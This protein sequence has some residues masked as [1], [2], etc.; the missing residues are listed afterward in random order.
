MCEWCGVSTA[1]YY[2]WRN[3]SPSRRRLQRAC[4]EAA[5]IETFY[6]FKQRYGAPRLT[7][8]LNESG[9][10][11]S[12]THVAT[13]MAENKL[14][15]RNGKR[16]RYTPSN[17]LFSHVSENRLKR[18]FE[19]QRPNEKWVSDITYIR[20]EKGFVYLAVIMDLFSRRIVGWAMDRKMTTDLVIEAFEMAVGNRKV[21]PGLVLHSDRGVQ[22]RS[23][24]YQGRLLDCG[25]QP[26]MSRKGNCWDNAVIESFFSRLKVES[27]HAEKF[28]GLGDAYTEV[29]EYIEL[30]YNTI[31]RH[32]SNGYL[33]PK[34][35]EQ[36]YYEQCA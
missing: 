14:K 23:G 20:I 4:V 6:Q 2:K 22:Y 26:S 32:S 13:L 18:R 17:N 28:K 16:F 33:S 34:Q 11:C 35:Y 5:V 19:A 3:R 29:F 24:E 21:K 30:F 1:G 25:V 7:V 27:I 36:Q 12:T 15:A 31:R 10:S 9:V 8:E